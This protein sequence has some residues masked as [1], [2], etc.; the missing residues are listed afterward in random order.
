MPSRLIS[1]YCPRCG[2][3]FFRRE[4]DVID[5]IKQSGL[6]QCKKCTLIVR[7]QLNSYPSGSKREHQ[8]KILI[9]TEKG[10]E[11][12][13]RVI[14]A[15]ILGRDIREDEAVHHINKNKKDNRPEN[16]QVMLHTEHT[17][18]H[19]TGLKRSEKTCMNISL[20]K[21]RKTLK[22]EDVINAK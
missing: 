20:A 4:S 21:R 22:R 10:W 19:H 15:G 6:W 17:I 7:N 16:L 2:N 5:T 14:M 3:E 18:L 1:V 8:G 11:L 13:H 12:E 9:K